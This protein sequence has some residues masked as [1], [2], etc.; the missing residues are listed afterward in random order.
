ME[1]TTSEQPEILEQ[2]TV[3]PVV[4]PEVNGDEDMNEASLDPDARR[5]RWQSRRPRIDHLKPAVVSHPGELNPETGLYAHELLCL[6]D[7]GDRIVVEVRTAHLRGTPWLN[8][9]VGK[10][11]TIDD[12]TGL[13]TMYDEESDAR[14]PMVR[15]VSFKDELHDFRLAP[16]KG[17]PFNVILAKQAERA[18]KAAAAAADPNAP[19]KRGRGRPK[20]SK[21]RSK[22]EIMAEREAYKAARE[23]KKGRR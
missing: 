6:F 7:V 9:I 12:E 23:A 11:R 10:V 21:N 22:E 16:A 2:P 8:T 1:A 5:A 18:A 3:G 13:V 17:N 14:N 20:G 15:Y 19:K 4:E